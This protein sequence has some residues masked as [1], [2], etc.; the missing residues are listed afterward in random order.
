MEK[1]N[2][3]KLNKVKAVFESKNIP[4]NFYNLQIFDTFSENQIDM[5]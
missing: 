2:R 5:A 4:N 3:N 1:K